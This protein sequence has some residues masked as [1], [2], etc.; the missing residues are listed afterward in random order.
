MTLPL[1]IFIFDREQSRAP[2]CSWRHLPVLPR[3][4]AEELARAIA[5]YAR[6][7]HGMDKRREETRVLLQ[8]ECIYRA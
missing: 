7:V 2:S 4:V 8:V 1:R 5:S 6:H 3:S